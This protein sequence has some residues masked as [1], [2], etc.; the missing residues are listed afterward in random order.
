MGSTADCQIRSAF[1]G[2]IHLLNRKTRKAETPALGAV[3]VQ[4]SYG[5]SSHV[6]AKQHHVAVADDVVLALGPHDA[7][8]ARAFP[9]VVRDELVVAD[10]LGA[11]ESALEV[12]VDHSR[13]DRRGV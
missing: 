3:A 2:T 12:G 8:L 4:S 1:G 11:D 9:S 10:R 7:L 5:T 13:G 6:E